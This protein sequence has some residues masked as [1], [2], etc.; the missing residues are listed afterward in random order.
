MAPVFK[1]LECFVAGIDCS[2]VFRQLELFCLLVLLEHAFRE[3]LRC[4]LNS[5][6]L[7]SQE[8]LLLAGERRTRLDTGREVAR[9]HLLDGISRFN[10]LRLCIGQLNP[11]AVK[12]VRYPEHGRVDAFAAL[13]LLG[14]LDRL[15]LTG[16]RALR[17]PVVGAG[18]E[19][20]AEEF[21]RFG[22]TNLR[23]SAE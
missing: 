3:N 1:R 8:V 2:L 13:F 9:E 4:V 14:A 12:L 17:N 7:G 10:V 11:V 15:I 23:Q 22:A 20:L 6:Q 16:K 21:E 5:G 19:D 18:A